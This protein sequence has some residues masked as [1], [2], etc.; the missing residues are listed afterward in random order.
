MADT[1]YISQVTLPNSG[2]TYSIKDASAWKAIGN[3]WSVIN[4]GSLELVVLGSSE[5]LPEASEG[6]KGKIYLKPDTTHN[7]STYDVY[8]EY[9]TVDKGSDTNP[10]YVWEKIGNTDVNLSQYSL[11]THKHE[12]DISISVNP[13]SYTPTGT[14]TKPTFTGTRFDSSGNY[15]PKGN[16]TVKTENKTATVSAA[17]SGEAT[18]TPAGTVDK[19]TFTGTEGNV[20]VSGIVKGA[21][22]S[23]TAAETGGHTHTVS[24]TTGYLHSVN[25]PTGFS[26]TS[27][28][29]NVSTSKLSLT[30]I[31]GTNGTLVTHD[32]PSLNTTLYGS[33]S[34]WSA[35]S[36]SNWSFTVASGSETLTIGGK[37][38]TVPSLTINNVSVGTSLKAG[39]MQTVAIAAGSATTVA[40]GSVST[41]G[42]GATVAISAGST[43]KAYTGINASTPSF[44]LNNT[45]SNGSAVIT[46]V[47]SSTGSSGTHTHTVS[48]NVDDVTVQSSGKF[49]PAGGV[50]APTFT[51][52]GVRLVTGNIEVPKTY[53]FSGTPETITVSGI[54]TGEVSA[55]TFNGS[56]ATLS[57]KVNGNGTATTSQASA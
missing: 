55:P 22:G 16:V 46:A 40:T 53:T 47:G 30:S 33:A 37:N 1:K 21:T 26:T 14:I 12:V 10:R 5:Q 56:T 29:T 42:T 38:G 48:V 39:T 51:G 11:N 18:Y 28:L 4:Q 31:T 36:A 6:T 44:T 32:T 25:V 23:G 43:T 52:T 24:G 3:L 50:S 15:T 9:V 49:T 20:T 34:G 27:V 17:E 2:G 7:P 35:G 45:A 19:P 54:A 8:D 41:G 57:H 13:H